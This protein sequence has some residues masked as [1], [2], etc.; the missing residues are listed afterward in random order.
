MATI[1]RKDGGNQRHGSRIGVVPRFAWARLVFIGLALDPAIDVYLPSSGGRGQQ[2]CHADF[3]GNTKI[4]FV[5]VCVQNRA[6]RL[7][8]LIN[9][10]LECAAVRLP[11]T[12]PVRNQ[13]E[14]TRITEPESGNVW[15]EPFGD[16][17]GKQ[18]NVYLA[19]PLNDTRDSGERPEVV[20]DLA[21][22]LP[23]EARGTGGHDYGESLPE[24]G[25]RHPSGPQLWFEVAGEDLLE[26]GCGAA[27]APGKPLPPLMFE[28]VLKKD[29]AN[30]QQ[31]E[32][33]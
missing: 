28:H 7:L 20:C 31:Q 15:L 11:Q 12:G 9:R 25:W 29:T 22:Q 6:W 19:C 18:R 17:I 8:P 23:G 4:G 3:G 1:R 2:R 16:V 10:A 21:L 33:V 14:I 30:V 26:L 24:F 32:L 27:R 5:V 13:N